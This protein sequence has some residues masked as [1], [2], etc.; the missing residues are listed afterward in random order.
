[1][2]TLLYNMSLNVLYKYNIINIIIKFF[3]L[4]NFYYKYKI[5]SQ[6]LKEEQ[7]EL[8]K[9]IS[10]ETNTKPIET[11]LEED[12]TSPESVLLKLGDI[13]IITDPTNEILNENEFIIDYIDSRKIKLINTLNFERT[14][15]NINKDGTIGDSTIQQIKIISRSPLE[16]YARQNNLLPKTWINIYFDGDYPVVFTGEITNLEEDMIEIQ[17]IDNDTLYINFN[18]QGI[19]EELPIA[20]FEIRPP[21]SI[22]K[23]ERLLEEKEELEKPL[24][25]LEEKEEL[26]KPLEE[27]EELE[28]KVIPAQ[29]VKEKL[30]R[31]IIEA[32]QIE[33][34]DA[35]KIQEY[36]TID[37]DK[38]RY[39]IEVQSNDLLEE[40]LST[41]PNIQ[42]TNN[43]L[44]NIH[45]MITRFIQLREISSTFDQNKN[46]IGVIKR[47]ADDKPLVEYLS[48]FKNSLYWILFVVKNIK[49]IYTSESVDIDDVTNIDQ[50]NDLLEIQQLFKQYK[51]N[52]SIEGQNK[53]VE[54]YKS[55]N[56][57]MTPFSLVNPQTTGTIYDSVN[58]IIIENQVQSDINAI[59]DNLEDL[60]SS[61][62]SNSDIRSKKYV[63]QKYNLGLDRLE[64]TS[65]KGSKMI[66]HRVKLTNNDTLTL[67]SIV[68]LPEPTLRFSQINLPGTNLLVRSNL[69]MHFLNY[70]LL[71]KQKT[72]YNPVEIN[73]LDFEF[74]YDENNF[75][76]DIKN[77]MLNLTEY[78]NKLTNLDVYK[79]FLNII[80]PKIKVL[81]N[82]VKKYIK[83]KLSMSDLIAYLEPFMIYTNDLT[84]INYNVMNSFIYEKIKEYNKKYVEYSRLFSALKNFK[85]KT[86][87]NNPLLNLLDTTLSQRIFGKYG[88][89]DET[90]INNVSS[91]ELLNDIIKKDYGCLLNNSITFTNLQLMY[92]NKLE[93]IFE[94]DKNKIKTQIDDD[95]EKDNCISYT[96][97]KK[98]YS[99]EAL[100]ND[101]NKL[102]FFDKQHDYT[103]YDL[104]DD[105]IRNTMTEDEMLIYIV[106]ELKNKHKY[107]EK[108]AEY[109]AETLINKQK[110]VIDG[111]Y[112]LLVKQINNEPETLEYYIRENDIWVFVPD[113]DPEAFIKEESILCNIQQDCLY[114][115]TENNCESLEV[116]KDVLVSNTL[117]QIMTQ[118]DKSYNISKEELTNKINYLLE[119]YEKN[120]EGLDKIQLN[121]FYKYNKIQ[122]ELGL[123]ISEEIEKHIIS[124]YAKLRD[125]IV[126]Q[127]DF[128]KKQSDIITFV[129]KFCRN[130]M[131]DIPNIHDNELENPW[132]LYCKK[133]DTKLLPLFRYILAKTFITNINDYENVLNQLKKDIGKIS[134]DGDSWVDENSGEVMCYI[135]YDV[136]EGFK[137]G[138]VNKTRDILEED[139]VNVL[140]EEKKGKKDIRLSADGQLVS[141]V[142]TAISNNMGILNSIEQS[143]DFIIKIVTELMNNTTVI[144]KES[145][146]K[147]REKEAAKK[148]KK[149]PEYAS[150]Y[151]STLM[152]LTLSTLLIAIQTS[153]PSI[154]TR[155]T[156][157]GCVRSF[158]GFPFEGE[159]DNSSIEYIACIAF[160]LKNPSVIP[161]S[162]LSRMNEDKIVSAIKLFTTKYL[163][164]NSDIEIRI[165][166]KLEY[167]QTNPEEDI[168]NEHRLDNWNE[169][170]PPL[171]RFHIKS[172]DNITSDFKK[173]LEQELKNGDLRQQ[174]NLLVIESKII[175]YS[176]MIQEE[177]QKIVDNKDLLLRSAMHPFMINACCNEKENNNLT[178][179]QYFNNENNN[180][181]INNDIINKLSGLLKDIKTLTQSA[182]FLSIVDTKRNLPDISK[183]FTEE[184]IYRAFIDFCRFQSSLAL[185][186]DLAAIC[187]DKPDY[188][189]K[190]D[191]IEEKIIKLKRD[192]RNY[193]KEMFL[194]LFQIVSRNNIIHNLVLTIGHKSCSETL[195]QAINI[196]SESND[197]NIA[198]SLIN[199][200][201]KLLE[202][203]ELTF[204]LA[205]REI[206]AMRTLKNY[207]ENSNTRMKK[208][209]LDY[210][211]QKANIRKSEYNNINKFI[212]ELTKWEFDNPDNIRNTDIKISDDSMYNYL[213][214]LR[215]FINMLVIIF[216]NMIINKQ[217]QNIEP[218]KYWGLSLTHNNDIKNMVEN[219]YDPIKSFYDNTN[220][221]NIL[222]EIQDKCKN[223]ILLSNNT[224]ALTNIK[225]GNKEIYHV[226]NKRIAT[227]LYEYYILQVF[228]D[229]IDLTN[230][231][232][233]VSRMLSI[234]ERDP[235]LTSTDFLIET[236]LRFSETEEQIIQGD[237]SKL[238][239]NVAKLLVAYIKIMMKSKDTI[240]LSYNSIQD[241]IFKLKEAEKYTFTDRLK[242]LTEEERK[243][244]TI[245]KSNKL[246]VWSKGLSKA[247]KVYD[248]EN[249][250]QDKILAEQVAELKN[251][252]RKNYDVSE[253]NMDVMMEDMIQDIDTTMLI[254]GEEYAMSHMNDDYN[255]GDYYGDE[256]E[257]IEDY[258]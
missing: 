152:F 155:K 173:K 246:G 209:I 66:A 144:E 67:K 96:I 121:N 171:N 151:N 24:E 7:S 1:M 97:A 142:I 76:D 205:D 25:E 255:D 64:A 250:D 224:P 146:Y 139:A 166:E 8:I 85:T 215:Y 34:G 78:E 162:S 208:V 95:K 203:Y 188:L 204:D 233:V 221:S 137:D 50:K 73:N 27:K 202:N 71:L 232:E 216:P 15:L 13:I 5:M 106:E 105:K 177:I 130:G 6:E 53:Y 211:K 38:Y 195:R 60:Y 80:I 181:S 206:D 134:D 82:L 196:I 65:L 114:K 70:W 11:I 22:R 143:R 113:I 132:F 4:K 201:D 214:Y 18:Y 176:M 129:D 207:L 133:T 240:N 37:K 63:I 84:Y 135:D 178:T 77:Y 23:E 198:G 218:P 237:I 43:V 59:V 119:Y 74:N 118:F 120:I 29:L 249:Y 236:Q 99:K 20:T 51:S 3:T 57:Y 164:S 256:I 251:K 230:D 234:S 123:S 161:W 124:P 213:N 107:S 165:R 100:E 68:T 91:S 170:L 258:N 122:Y 88:Y 79:N 167:L 93:D 109:E 17:T 28:E 56:N 9:D 186:D 101:N 210:I 147:I 45:I 83:G 160:K 172:V 62:I 180:I 253:R 247:I 69:N 10:I 92:P 168:P 117:K 239:E 185:T 14:Q 90:K 245:M 47:S 42:R 110:K 52:V 148:G 49:K 81:F 140:I 149:L 222:Y 187:S 150:V 127:S 39:N 238:Q 102:I 193:T 235:N 141:N 115:S 200:L 199:G 54:L 30:K 40:M 75:L 125:L 217:I 104:L 87:Y 153:I 32:D 19:P 94:T 154:K 108:D 21:P 55:L 111:Q 48:S 158:R 89:D 192:G 228:N 41:I 116:A 128:V 191:S 219:F 242:E 229:Y 257:N 159:G 254:E 26:E 174:D 227:L 231:P 226:F 36:I 12:I 212:N 184:T 16:G 131:P 2:V 241:N 46:I 58:G 138:F 98:Y 112:A 252:L 86:R 145:A 72:V 225:I 35:I 169:F 182:I 33:F 61:V 197:D 248:P 183:D 175:G 156:F 244:D 189:N 243:V 220:I 103:N 163:L 190:F 136:T 194:R 31:L 179:L 223:I 44:N 126:G 157:P